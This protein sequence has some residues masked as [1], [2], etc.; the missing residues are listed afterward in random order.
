MGVC[1]GKIVIVWC[2]VDYVTRSAL[3][4]IPSLKSRNYG[5]PAAP[6]GFKVSEF[7]S[8]GQLK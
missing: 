3:A 5:A 4:S 6:A 2:F 8:G 1:Y 7:A